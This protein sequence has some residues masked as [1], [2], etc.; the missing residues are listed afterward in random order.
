MTKNDR[1]ARALLLRPPPPQT[2]AFRWFRV[3]ERVSD[4]EAV[5][6]DRKRRCARFRA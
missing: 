4:S 6:N 5:E 2:N 1:R 3:A